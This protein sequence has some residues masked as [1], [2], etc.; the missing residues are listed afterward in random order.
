MSLVSGDTEIA[1]LAAA[2]ASG[3]PFTVIDS[4]GKE[5]LFHRA[6]P[7]LPSWFNHGSQVTNDRCGIS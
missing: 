4:V 2:F 5:A 1:A 6:N 7:P 3:D